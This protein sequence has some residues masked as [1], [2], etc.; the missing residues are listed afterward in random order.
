SA[1]DLAAARGYRQRHAEL[2]RKIQQGALTPRQLRLDL[3]K[4]YIDLG[5]R[6]LE[7]RF[8]RREKAGDQ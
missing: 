2:Y 8:F 7:R 5:Q 3:V 1:D 6:E 4:F